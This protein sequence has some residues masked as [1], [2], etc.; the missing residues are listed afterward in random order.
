MC[1]ECLRYI[2]VDNTGILKLSEVEVIEVTI[3]VLGISF[4]TILNA[5]SFNFFYYR[6]SL[7]NSV[8]FVFHSRNWSRDNN[9]RSQEISV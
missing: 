1:Y 6:V 2:E 5:F 4:S 7:D 3:S 9:Y 8:F